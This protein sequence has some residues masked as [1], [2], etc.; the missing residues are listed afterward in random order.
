MIHESP[1]KQ[2][3]YYHPEPK[4]FDPEVELKKRIKKAQDEKL[5]PKG[6]ISKLHG[7]SKIHNK[8]AGVAERNLDK[9]HRLFKLGDK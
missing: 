2:K 5:K 9:E 6:H 1:N 4:A 3:K 8:R 7:P